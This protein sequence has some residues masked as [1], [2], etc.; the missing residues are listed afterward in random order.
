VTSSTPPTHIVE[1]NSPDRVFKIDVTDLHGKFIGD[2]FLGG[3]S[4]S[5]DE[6]YVCYVAQ[7]KPAKKSTSFELDGKGNKFDYE[8]DWGGIQEAFIFHLKTL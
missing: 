5:S 4:W 1:I 2:S 7:A 3:V 6:R 8:E